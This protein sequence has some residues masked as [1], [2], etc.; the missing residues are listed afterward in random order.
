MGRRCRYRDNQPGG[1]LLPKS[2]NRRF[3]GRACCQTII[4][5]D[6]RPSLDRWRRPVTSIEPFAPLELT[7][8]A[9]GDDVDGL[10]GD[11]QLPDNTFM[12][13]TNITCCDCPHT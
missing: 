9:F 7:L 12:Q 2:S 6:H 4:D 1:I 13:Y 5:N 11:A 3:H 8:L 10:L